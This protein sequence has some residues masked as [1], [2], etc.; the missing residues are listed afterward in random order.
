MTTDRAGQIVWHDLFTADRPRALSFYERVTGWAYA[1]EHATDFVWG[2][3]EKDFVLAMSGD[4]AGAGIAETPGELS[5]G[6][7]AYA[8]VRDVDAAA[9]MA[10]CLG[11]TILKPPFDVPGVGRNALLR[12]P[13]GARIGVSLTRHNFPVPERQFGPEL[14]LSAPSGFPED[15]YATLF[16]W[17]VGPATE[18]GRARVI[19][20]ASG[21]ETAMLV[22]AGNRAED[23]PLWV[24]GLKVKDP[25]ASARDALSFGGAR[26]GDSPGAQGET[27]QV[28]LCDPDGA[29]FALTSS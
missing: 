4:E 12:D 18:H 3:G 7:L 24:P 16:G 22:A 14:Y 2:G 17:S 19:A 26:F 5:G 23:G 28:L 11:G 21:A 25:A 20:D 13:L 8:E 6:W 15:F 9:E 10:V 29:V 1:I 27:R